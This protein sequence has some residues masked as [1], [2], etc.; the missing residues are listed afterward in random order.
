[1]SATTVN[2]TYINYS[3]VGRNDDT[4]IY[5]EENGEQYQNTFIKLRISLKSV[6]EARAAR[7]AE[8]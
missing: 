5:K 6:P 1:M 3:I 2:V 8:K 7:G 4:R